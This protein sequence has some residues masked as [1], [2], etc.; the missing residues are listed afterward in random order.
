[1][2]TRSLF[3]AALAL[4]MLFACTKENIN[5]SVNPIEEEKFDFTVNVISPAE[6][7]KAFF[8]DE[9]GI[10]WKDVDK[11]GGIINASSKYESTEMS[12]YSYGVEG[13]DNQASFKFTAAEGNYRFY[14]PHHSESTFNKIVFEVDT[15]QTTGV[16][17]SSDIFAVISEDLVSLTSNKDLA[18]NTRYQVVGSYIQFLVYGKENEQVKSIAVKCDDNSRISGQYYVDGNINSLTGVYYNGQ[19]IVLDLQGAYCPTTPDKESAKGL[20]AAILPSS[21][22][23]VNGTEYLTA[24]N[25]Y[26]VTTDGGIYTFESATGKEFAFGSIKTIPLNLNRATKF[27]KTPEKLYII[28]GATK[29]GWDNTNP[30]ELTKVDGTN[31]FKGE[32]IRL[33]A[34]KGDSGFKFLTTKGSWSKVYVNGLH[35][36]KTITYYE[37][38][39]RAGNDEKF[40]VDKDGF[41][42][43]TVDFDT[44]KIT[45]EASIP[46]FK[47]TTNEAKWEDMKPTSK[48]GVY[49]HT[50]WFASG[51]YNH[52][53]R[54]MLN[55]KYYHPESSYPMINFTDNAEFVKGLTYS[56]VSDDNADGGWWINDDWTN[57]C[58]IDVVFDVNTGKVTVKYAQG[59]KFWL[60]GTP[61]GGYNGNVDK[62]PMAIIDENGIAKWYNLEVTSTGDFKICGENR[63][64][65]FYDEKGEWYFS[66]EN[67]YGYGS[68]WS[69]QSSANILDTNDYKWIIKDAG[70]YD[71]E[72]DTVNLKLTV[73]KK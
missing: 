20:Y 40:S 37:D 57:R 60:I 43:V 62:N 38:P 50:R 51:Q 11:K 6:K 49:K 14:Y 39:E 19:D 65:S 10:Y 29:A 42:T 36:N 41:Y 34:G 64:S 25:T 32:N 66:T 53:F 24:K 26:V 18:A 31:Q 54:I 15:Y 44:N 28:G 47:I 17:A 68:T 8:S 70:T 5:P 27:S 46:Q 30:I 71:V 21:T 2:K 3:A 58:N 22:D 7:T 16:G 13:V 69:G 12:H 63:L 48:P 1:M 55:G 45:C 72:F 67:G 73:T 61:F 59:E 56:T 23:F 4:P 9:N 33:T 35:D 52:D